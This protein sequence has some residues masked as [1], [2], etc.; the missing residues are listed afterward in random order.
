MWLSIG[1]ALIGLL[2]LTTSV[3]GLLLNLYILVGAA[4]E[5][6]GGN[7]LR[8][9]VTHNVFY[10]SAEIAIGLWLIL[11]ARGFREAFWWAQRA[12]VRKSSS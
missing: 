5:Y 8:Q 11:G 10:N 3:P 7:S 2:L 6:G 9:D 4:T 12:G 1:C